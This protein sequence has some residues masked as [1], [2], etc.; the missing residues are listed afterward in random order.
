MADSD[1]ATRLDTILEW[2]KS[3]QMSLEQAVEHVRKLHFPEPWSPAL[4]R[5]HEEHAHGDIPVPDS[6]TFQEISAAY[7]RGDLT[8]PEYEA[9]AEAAAAAMRSDGIS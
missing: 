8:R 3:G 2:L 7:S 6:G 5:R 9:L 1:Q 4:G